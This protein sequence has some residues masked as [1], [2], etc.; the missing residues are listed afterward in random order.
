VRA[1]LEALAT[2]P[3]GPEALRARLARLDP[4]SAERIAPQN[5]RRIIRAIEIVETTGA[6]RKSTV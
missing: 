3:G 4:A 2:Q 6:D 1:D 5:L